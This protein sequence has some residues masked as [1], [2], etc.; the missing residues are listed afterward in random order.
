VSV[1]KET[2]QDASTVV[3]EN[4]T[5]ML[6]RL[7]PSAFKKV[8]WIA[9]Q[10][11]LPE[12]MTMSLTVGDGGSIVRAVEEK[13]GRFSLLDKELLFTEKL[14]SLGSLGDVMLVD[15]SQYT[16]GIRKELILEKSNAPG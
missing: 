7:H 13:N 2:A 11:T 10:T 12:F 1:A 15:P 6:A 8:V 14:P 3:Y 9:N 4:I 5:K 16:I